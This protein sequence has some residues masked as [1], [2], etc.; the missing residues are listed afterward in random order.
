MWKPLWEREVWQFENNNK[1]K[2]VGMLMDVNLTQIH[3]FQRKAGLLSCP[4]LHLLSPLNEALEREPLKI[5]IFLSLTFT[6]MLDVQTLWRREAD[7]TS[8]DLIMR[9]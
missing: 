1:G 8:W 9:R 4:Y 3:V 2:F 7:G 6:S 5:A